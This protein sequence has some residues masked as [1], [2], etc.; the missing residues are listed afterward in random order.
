MSKA[1]PRQRKA[2]SISSFFPALFISLYT[3]WIPEWIKGLLNATQL[4]TL[5]PY[6]KLNLMY[7]TAFI[8]SDYFVKD[9]VSH[10]V[11]TDK[12]CS[13]SPETSF[14]WIHPLQLLYYSSGTYWYSAVTQ[15][16]EQLIGWE[17]CAAFSQQ[18]SLVKYH[19][20]AHISYC[21]PYMHRFSISFIFLA[22]VR[23]IVRGHSCSRGGV[24]GVLMEKQHNT[25]WGL[26][27]LKHRRTSQTQGTEMCVNGQEAVC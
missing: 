24:K 21:S 14:R 11:L 8:N 23:V 26:Q 18:H 1:R 19:S 2:Y 10:F 15:P 6:R 3:T 17:L 5:H 27:F 9:S 16:V 20:I 7:F 12:L 4:S 25:Y 22:H 13:L